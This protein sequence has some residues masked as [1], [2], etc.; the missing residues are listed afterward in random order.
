MFAKSFI[1]SVL[2]ACSALAAPS[3]SIATEL[4]KRGADATDLADGRC[5]AH[6]YAE[7]K[8]ILSLYPQPKLIVSDIEEGGFVLGE[9]SLSYRIDVYDNTGSLAHWDPNYLMKP[10]NVVNKAIDTSKGPR[11]IV[12][13]NPDGGSS[14]DKITLSYDKQQWNG[15]DCRDYIYKSARLSNN[16]QNQHDWWCQFDC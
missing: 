7:S 15:N 5:E 9:G 3:H 14:R 2:L 16:S 1:T 13:G 6:I 4:E 12:G 10:E 8:V 11:F